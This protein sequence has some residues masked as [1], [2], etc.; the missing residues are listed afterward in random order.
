VAE[1]LEARRR[2]VQ[3]IRRW[4]VTLTVALFLTVQVVI[5][6]STALSTASTHAKVSSSQTSS[7]AVSTRTS[8]SAATSNPA[9]TSTGSVSSPIS[10]GQS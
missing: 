1:L 10:T 7:G 6:R 3:T 2:R 4:V 8:G 5:F 9:A